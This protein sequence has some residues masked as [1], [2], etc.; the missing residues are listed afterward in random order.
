MSLERPAFDLLGLH[1]DLFGELSCF[2]ASK[3][4]TRLWATGNK[5]LQAILSAKDVVRVLR[6]SA[7][8]RDGVQWE[9]RL[10]MLYR[11][12]FLHFLSVSVRQSNYSLDVPSIKLDWGELPA[13]LTH[14]RLYCLNSVAL[15]EDQSA[16]SDGDIKYHDIGSILPNLRT[17]DLSG[18][19]ACQIPLQS[20]IHWPD[21]L[22]TLTIPKGRISHNE[23]AKLSPSLTSLNISEVYYPAGETELLPLGPNLEKLVVSNRDY[24]G[25]YRDDSLSVVGQFTNHF[26]L[27]PRS[28]KYFR[29]TVKGD[30]PTP[31]MLHLPTTLTIL[32]F[33]MAG[34]D[35]QSLSH[36]VNLQRLTFEARATGPN[37]SR[38]LPRGLVR[39]AMR[40]YDHTDDD[41]WIGLPRDLTAL[42]ILN[43]STSRHQ[44]TNPV[45]AEAIP[46][47]PPLLQELDLKKIREPLNAEAVAKLSE[48]VISLRI[49]D[50]EDDAM[51]HL[52][53]SLRSLELNHANLTKEWIVALPPLLGSLHATNATITDPTALSHFPKNLTA[54]MIVHHR[55]DRLCVFTDEMA[56]YLPPT[57]QKLCIRCSNEIGDS[58]IG[59]LKI[60]M[61]GHLELQSDLGAFTDAVIPLLPRH[62]TWLDLYGCDAWT[63]APEMLCELPRTLTWCYLHFRN[64]ATVKLLPLAEITPHLPP[65]LEHHSIPCIE[66][67]PSNYVY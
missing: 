59:A 30:I 16:T 51:A 67:P 23:L 36:L 18:C 10:R 19:R 31:S 57:L 20:Q 35:V 46:H 45:T 40:H 26:D 42:N 49:L 1:R 48:K 34:F 53:R 56:S 13:S 54:L 63:Y 65:N 47:I 7:V 61:L 24:R 41:F 64:P 9:G 12:P 6:C 5:S 28:L 15:L 60:P 37:V 32:E 22:S 38:F 29:C 33:P 11:F 2:L 4:V 17:L 3:D 25:D 27:L 66:K 43:L 52:P 58:F 14:L 8:Q 50:I 44:V 39:L 21:S 55:A 62:L